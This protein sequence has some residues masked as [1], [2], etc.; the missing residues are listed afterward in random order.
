MSP[1]FTF[2]PRARRDVLEQMLYFE[3]QANEDTALKYYKAV[4][5]TCHLLAKQP[6]GGKAFPTTVAALTGL[7]RFPLSAPFEK[8]LLFYRPSANGI[9]VVR[10]LYGSRDLEPILAAEA[11]DE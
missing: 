9:E 6:F 3:E 4:L 7:R 11:A 1:S 8:Y 5:T 10:V 2:R